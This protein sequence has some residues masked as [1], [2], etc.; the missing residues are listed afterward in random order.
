MPDI[1]EGNLFNNNDQNVGIIP[2][3]F[4]PTG[5]NQVEFK[6]KYKLFRWK[7]FFRKNYDYRI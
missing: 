7:R 2:K 3:N 1:I 4:D 6:R 5:T